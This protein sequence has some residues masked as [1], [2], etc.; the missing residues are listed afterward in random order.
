MICYEKLFQLQK[1]NQILFSFLEE[2]KCIGYGGLVH[3]NW[4]DI[5]GEISFIIDTKLEKNDNSKSS[6]TK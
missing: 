3:I 1:P 5:N 2:N 4:N 6:K